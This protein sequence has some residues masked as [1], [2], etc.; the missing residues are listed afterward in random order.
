MDCLIPGGTGGG[1]V[2]YKLKGERDGGGGLSSAE[3]GTGPCGWSCLRIVG[4]SSGSGALFYTAYRVKELRLGAWVKSTYC[5]KKRYVQDLLF[6]STSCFGF[7]F[8]CLLSPPGVYL[9]SA[10]DFDAENNCCLQA[11]GK[12]FLLSYV[13]E[14]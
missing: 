8:S 4:C 3:E 1:S 11:A 13:I 9:F 10:L 14:Y 2:I 12:Q 7:F 6:L 5:S